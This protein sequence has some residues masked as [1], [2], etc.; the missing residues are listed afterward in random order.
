MEASSPGE[1]IRSIRKRRGISQ[2]DLAQRAG[3]SRSLVEKLEEG[4]YGDVRLE[5]LMKLAVAL[6]VPTSMLLAVRADD[7]R[8]SGDAHPDTAREWEPVRRALAGNVPQPEEEATAA[9]VTAAW[10]RLGPALGSHRY[11]AVLAALP[12]LLRDTEALPADAAGRQVRSDVLTT[13]G[14]LLT[15]T[16]QFAVAELTLLRA[17]D[18]A[19]GHRL[20]AAAA[21]DTLTWLYLRQGRLAEARETA[22]RWADDIEPRF[23]RATTHELIL[24]GRFLLGLTNAA[25]RDNRPG[26]G[27]RARA[28]CRR[29]RADR[30]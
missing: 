13:T 16:R 19:G 27:R 28:G 25:V 12:A 9:G 10:R 30:P 20:D 22:V 15:Q 8:E 7:N 21:A 5:T 24:W 6:R 3:V 23:S 18:A 29:C 17:I 4:T 26:E 2:R 11:Q 1:R 14:Y